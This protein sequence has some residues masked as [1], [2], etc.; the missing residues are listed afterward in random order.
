[1]VLD[2]SLQLIWQWFKLFFLPFEID[3]KG[4]KLLAE[5]QRSRG[6]EGAQKSRETLVLPSCPGYLRFDRHSAG[7]AGKKR[8][9]EGKIRAAQ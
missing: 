2:L 1:M 4:P 9:S 5:V 3:F 6:A 8:W 7:R